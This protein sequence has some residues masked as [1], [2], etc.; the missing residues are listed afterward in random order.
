MLSRVKR[1]EVVSLHKSL[2]DARVDEH[3]WKNLCERRGHLLESGEYVLGYEAMTKGRTVEIPAPASTFAVTV[4][5]TCIIAS[6][7]PGTLLDAFASHVAHTGLRLNLGFASGYVWVQ[8]MATAEM[9][10]TDHDGPCFSGRHGLIRDGTLVRARVLQ[11][12]SDA[13]SDRLQ[14]VAELHSIHPPA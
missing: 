8:H 10:F 14:F 2:F 3:I 1:Q 12:R 13:V 5:T 7:A 9:S 6:L 11:A 4:E